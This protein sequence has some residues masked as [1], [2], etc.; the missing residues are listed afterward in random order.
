MENS[1]NFVIQF[2]LISQI[3]YPYTVYKDIKGTSFA[4]TINYDTS[5]HWPLI[6]QSEEC[7]SLIHLLLPPGSYGLTQSQFDWLSNIDN[8]KESV[9]LAGQYNWQDIDISQFQGEMIS[10]HLSTPAVSFSETLPLARRSGVPFTPNR[11]QCL[12]CISIL[13]QLTIQSLTIY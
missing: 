10:F 12:A 8:L 11:Q 1:R 6:R 4:V 9:R 7:H 5:D 2:L 3:Q 13:L